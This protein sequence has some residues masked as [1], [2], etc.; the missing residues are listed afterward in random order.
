VVTCRPD[1]AAKLRKL[2]DFEIILLCDDSGSMNQSVD[3]DTKDPFATK[4]R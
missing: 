4:K 2:E 3:V 1:F